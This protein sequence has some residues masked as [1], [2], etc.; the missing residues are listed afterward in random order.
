[1]CRSSTTTTGS[2]DC[3]AT[4]VGH[5]GPPEDEET[6]DDRE[7]RPPDAIEPQAAAADD[8]VTV[9]DSRRVG[10]GMCLDGLQL[11]H[12]Q[13][14]VVR[15]VCADLVPQ[16]LQKRVP[17]QRDVYGG[18]A[19]LHHEAQLGVTEEGLQPGGEEH[20]PGHVHLRPL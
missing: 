5:L 17:D 2:A 3:S 12:A 4:A 10:G 9:V 16:R 14:A 11:C 20:D 18:G 6:D 8:E 1:M 13:G 19:D 15:L 7:Q